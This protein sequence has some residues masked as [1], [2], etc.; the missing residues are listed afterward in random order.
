MSICTV[1]FI[2]EP[3]FTG[4]EVPVPYAFGGGGGDIGLK[5]IV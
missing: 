3:C 1:L 4:W 2:E 5:V